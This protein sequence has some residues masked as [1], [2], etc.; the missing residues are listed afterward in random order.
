MAPT[1]GYTSP[2]NVRLFIEWTKY[3]KAS[4]WR[5]DAGRNNSQFIPPESPIYIRNDTG[6]AIPAFACL[7]CTGTVEAGGQSYITVDKPVDI[8]GTAG[9]YL[10]NGIAPIEID[11]YG[12]AY[13]GPLVRM[14]TDGSSI[15]CGDT[16]QPQV[17]SFEVVPG[18]SMFSAV[19]EDDIE[20]DVMRAFIVVP[21][22]SSK[23][24]ARMMAAWASNVASCEIYT[25]AG[26]TVVYKEVADVYDPLS[27]LAAL[28]TDD[29]M[30]CTLQGGLYYA[31]DP[32]S[33]PGTSPLIAN[34][35]ET[36]PA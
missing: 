6:E 30:Y 10:F 22:G 14:L 18:G 20:T 3:L 11:G 5:I 4:G 21:G 24:A 23:Y 17:A 1:G 29:W 27:V 26:A 9:G 19:G 35:P 33:C 25:L 36:Q 12:L 32:A 15:V 7:Q 31:A 2:E 13:D 16:W 28:S 34:P 8:T